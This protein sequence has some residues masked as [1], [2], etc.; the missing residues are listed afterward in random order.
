MLGSKSYS[1][2]SMTLHNASIRNTV[3][4]FTENIRTRN[5]TPRFTPQKDHIIYNDFVSL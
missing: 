1:D 4:Q 2:V 3:E 5:N